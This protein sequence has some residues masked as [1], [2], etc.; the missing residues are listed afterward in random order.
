[1]RADSVAEAV[2]GGANISVLARSYA[3]P[4]DQI[5]V[6]PQLLSNLRPDYAQALTDAQTGEVVGPFKIEGAGSDNWAVVS[7]TLREAERPYTLADVREQLVV[8]LQEA[9]MIDQ[10]VEDLRSSIYVAVRM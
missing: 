9:R 2:R 5:E 1:M 7:V 6:A 4:E 8:Q 3:T 10:I